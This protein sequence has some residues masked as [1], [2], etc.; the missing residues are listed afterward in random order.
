MTMFKPRSLFLGLF[1]LCAQ[2]CSTSDP[3]TEQ[4][5][6]MQAGLYDVTL[7]GSTVVALKSEGRTTQVCLDSSGAAQ[8]PIDPLGPLVKAWSTCSSQ[9]DEPRGNA[10]SGK[11]MCR[12][13]KTPMTAT[14]TGSHTVDSFKIEGKVTQGADET[15]EMMRLGSGD[16][17]LLGKRVADC[18]L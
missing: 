8:F 5:V 10:M 7:G 18:S 11:R 9:L 1:A 3:A 4:P 12:E 6:V 13:R 17:S 16:F 15:E 14:Y 2:G